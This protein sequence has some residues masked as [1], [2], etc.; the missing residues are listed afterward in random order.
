MIIS[1]LRSY[2]NIIKY[3]G[4]ILEDIRYIQQRLRDILCIC[5]YHKLEE[6]EP[7]AMH[8]QRRRGIDEQEEEKERAIDHRS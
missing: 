7:A 6:R 8:H 1:C 2:K 3:N 5:R 4:N